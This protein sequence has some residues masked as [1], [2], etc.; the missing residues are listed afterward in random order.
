MSL[1]GTAGPD[2]SGGKRADAD[3][4]RHA[5]AAQ[6]A[7]PRKPALS[8][9]LACMPPSVRHSESARSASGIE[10]GPA[11]A[12]GKGPIDRLA[13]ETP[14]N[15]LSIVRSSSSCRPGSAA[16]VPRA[17]T[18]AQADMTRPRHLSLRPCV[19]P[20][21]ILDPVLGP[22]PASPSPASD[23]YPTTCPDGAC[24]SAK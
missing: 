23:W 22:A 19:E 11:R 1:S 10:K 13:R 14:E 5:A 9:E 3:G 20:V 15:A 17:G 8:G 12:A 4:G 2:S 18:S 16:Y 21:P 7:P 6:S 24:L